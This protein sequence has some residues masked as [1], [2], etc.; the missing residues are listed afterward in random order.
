MLATSPTD[1]HGRPGQKSNGFEVAPWLDDLER[2]DRATFDAARPFGESRAVRTAFL[3]ITLAALF[4]APARAD[5]YAIA[6]VVVPGRSDTDIG[7]IDAST[8]TRLALPA[9]I[10]TTADER[11]PS[12]SQDGRRLAFERR[13]SAA[14]TVRIIAADV[15]SAQTLDLFDA[16]SAVRNRPT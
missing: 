12:I 5:V 4:A 10:N 15:V 6:Q 2:P 7:L 1:N 11:H 9:G 14:G 13:D 3:A 8:G 16:F